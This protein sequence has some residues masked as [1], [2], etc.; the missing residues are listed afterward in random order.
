MTIL[1]HRGESF[2]SNFYYF[3][4]QD[5]DYSFLIVSGKKKILLVPKLNEKAAK[6]KFKGKV[7]TYTDPF[8]ELK[9]LLKGRKVQVDGKAISMNLAKRLRRFC[10]LEDC[11]E[12][13]YKIRSKKKKEE[14]EKIRKAVKITKEIFH[15]V[16]MKD[17]S[18][19]MD[20][21]KLLL[22][23]T[24][25]RG[26]EPAF[27][28]IVATGKNSSM[29]HHVSGNKKLED[30][31]LVDYGVKYERYCADL[32]RCYFQEKDSKYEQAYERLQTAFDEIIDSI[33]DCKTG[34]EV[35]LAAEKAMRKTKF[36]KMIHAI[37]HGIG[38]RVHE[39]PRFGRRYSDNV[40]NTVF[41]IEPAAYFKDFGVRFEQNIHFNGKRV[42]VL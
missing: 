30:I 25:E 9:K 32:T 2:D 38:L 29:P 19:E 18:T 26:L 24:L 42:R 4:G 3:S 34:K 7:I 5:F 12:E 39:F 8:K 14:I 27:K 20:L 41:A 33:P 1:L 28:P 21:K 23:E 37:G 16:E 6:Q 15:A 36:P 35:A 13:L 11:A 17:A 22:K 31:V 40:K 10:K